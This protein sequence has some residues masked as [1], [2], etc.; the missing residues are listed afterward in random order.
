MRGMRPP[1]GRKS[2]RAAVATGSR[3][4]DPPPAAVRRAKCSQ[5][6]RAY[7]RPATLTAAELC[8]QLRAG[9]QRTAV[10]ASL[11]R[12]DVQRSS[13]PAWSNLQSMQRWRAS[14]PSLALERLKTL[15]EHV[16][17]SLRRRRPLRRLQRISGGR[18]Q[19]HSE[20]KVPSRGDRHRR[21]P[22]SGRRRLARG[23]RRSAYQVEGGG[24]A[25]R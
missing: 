18:R 5:G 15:R 13:G 3:D 11:T 17:L 23:W 4:H 14:G 7:A 19:R 24:G 2:A 25:V 10:S 16:L 20:R 6:S 21:L 22:S 12:R 9:S 1:T 8:W